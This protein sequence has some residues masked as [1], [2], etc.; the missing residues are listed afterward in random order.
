MTAAITRPGWTRA[1]LGT[2]LAAAFGFGLVIA[3][4]TNTGLPIYQTEQTGY[5]H[6]IVPLILAPLGF[7]AGFGCFDYWLR[8]A[9]GITRPRSRWPDPTGLEKTR[10]YRC[11]SASAHAR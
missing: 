9:A 4:R 3:L 8:W 2:V 7:L 5:P 1:A 6:V 11:G 10:R